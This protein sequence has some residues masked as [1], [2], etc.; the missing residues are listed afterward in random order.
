VAE[1]GQGVVWVRVEEHVCSTGVGSRPSTCLIVKV[2]AS[3]AV[4]LHKVLYCVTG[5]L[6]Q[7]AGALMVPLLLITALQKRPV[8]CAPL[9]C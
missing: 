9:S 5:T 6:L 3:Q 8:S 2:K 1:R 4:L 7:Q